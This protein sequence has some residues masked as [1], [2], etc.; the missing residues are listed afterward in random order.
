MSDGVHAEREVDRDRG[1][2]HSP[3]FY[4]VLVK[5]MSLGREKRMRRRLVEIGSVGA[6]D[7]VLDVGCGTGTLLRTVAEHAPTVG[8]LCGLDPSTEMVAHARHLADGRGVAI[9]FEQGFADALPYPDQSFDV[10]FCTFV[11]HHLPPSTK[12]AAFREMRR[13][14][15]TDGRLVIADFERG[16]AKP[17][18]T[19]IHDTIGRLFHHRG[20]ARPVASVSSATLL[21][22]G[23]DDV[24]EQ[25][26]G[27]R[28]IGVWIAAAKAEA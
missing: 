10:V 16:H 28:S 22:A 9:E 23:F 7:A 12:D 27:M 5:V 20:E 15:R 4:D 24:Q 13:V 26:L 6:G 14:L 25:R 21:A 3:R 2:L 11:I 19:R 8:R 1:I 17:L 18:G